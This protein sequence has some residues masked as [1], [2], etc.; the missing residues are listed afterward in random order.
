DE[1]GRTASAIGSSRTVAAVRGVARGTRSPWFQHAAVDAQAR[2]PIDRTRIRRSIQRS[3]RLAPA[4]PTRPVQPEARPPRLGARRGGHR[5]LAQAH[6]AGAKKNA[7]RQGRLIIF[8]DESGGSG[9]AT[10]V[11]NRAGRGEAAIAAV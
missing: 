6:V 9:R 8:I 7:A 11:N 1:Q 4:W 10:R 5:A 3:A 2:A